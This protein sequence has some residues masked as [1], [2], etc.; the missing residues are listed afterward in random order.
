MPKRSASPSQERPRREPLERTSSARRTSSFS[1]HC[2]DSPPKSG[3]AFAFKRER[4][5]PV[6][7]RYASRNPA[8]VPKRK[9]SEKQGFPRPTS[10]RR[11]LEARSERYAGAGSNVVKGREGGSATSV[12][13]AILS[14]TVFVISGSAGAPSAV[15]NL[16]PR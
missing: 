16:M 14:S 5:A 3:S 6:P 12:S 8:E 15:E 4:S 2:G 13:A 9:S 1:P 10:S 11:T 7:P